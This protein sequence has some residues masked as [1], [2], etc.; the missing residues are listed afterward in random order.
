MWVP[1]KWKKSRKWTLID[2][3]LVLFMLSTTNR[4][5]NLLEPSLDSDQPFLTFQLDIDYS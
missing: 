2:I 3:N 1:G 4:D 5:A